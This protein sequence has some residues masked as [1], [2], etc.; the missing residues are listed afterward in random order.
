MSIYAKFCI[1][2]S[3]TLNSVLNFFSGAEEIPPNGFSAEAMLHFSNDPYPTAST[4]A[5]ELTLTTKHEKYADF[6]N[7]FTTALQTHGGFGKL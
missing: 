3:M 5:L 1:T 2:G 4:C 6:K 7:N